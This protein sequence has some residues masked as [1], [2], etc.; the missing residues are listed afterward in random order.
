MASQITRLTI[1]YSNGYS[2]ANKKTSKLR[3]TGRWIPLHKGLVTRKM[4]PFD[5][6]IMSKGVHGSV[7]ILR[8]NKTYIMKLELGGYKPFS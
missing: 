6:I 2:V 4:F 8:T 5:V 3:V 1:V 7:F